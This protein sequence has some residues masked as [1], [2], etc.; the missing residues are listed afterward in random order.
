MSRDTALPDDPQ[1]LKGM[2]LSLTRER[3]TA[4]RGHD[5][6]LREHNRRIA[7]LTQERDAAHLKAR[8]LEIEK[9]RLEVELLRLTRWYY[10][11]KADQLTC[12]QDVAQMLLS[13]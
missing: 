9:L 6:A 7:L 11:R 8:E 10:G 1:I 13:F 2:V 5:A 3:D 12:E 4:T